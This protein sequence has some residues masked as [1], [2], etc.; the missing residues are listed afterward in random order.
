VEQSI[1]DNPQ[2]SGNAD[3]DDDGSDAAEAQRRHDAA[4]ESAE[5]VEYR[6]HSDPEDHRVFAE[7]NGEIAQRHDAVRNETAVTRGALIMPAPRVP[8]IDAD[9]ADNIHEAIEKRI[10]DRQNVP[11]ITGPMRKRLERIV[12]TLIRGKQVNARDR[13]QRVK[14]PG[15]FTTENILKWMDANNLT[16]VKSS[17]WS[18]A[19]FCSAI[20][21]LLKTVDPCYDFS[22]KVKAEPMAEK[23]PPRMLIA[24]GDKGQVMSLLVVK[25]I[26]DLTFSVYEGRSIK[27][28]AKDVAMTRVAYNLRHAPNKRGYQGKRVSALEGD[29]SAW[30]TTCTVPVRNMVENPIIMHVTQVFCDHCSLVPTSWHKEHYAACVEAGTTL[31]LAGGQT[32]AIWA[33]RRSGHRGTSILNWITNFVCWLATTLENGEVL[34]HPGALEATDLQGNKVCM[35]MAFEGDDSAIT[36]RGHNPGYIATIEENWKSLGFNMKLFERDHDKGEKM[37]FC[38]WF[39]SLNANGPTGEMCPDL[40]RSIRNMGISCSPAAVVAARDKDDNTLKAIATAKALSYAH[41]YRKYVP[42]LSKK[43]L[44]YARTLDGGITHLEQQDSFKVF[45]MAEP[46]EGTTFESLCLDIER[47][48]ITSEYENRILRTFGWGASEDEK[49]KFAQW[50]WDFDR[51]KG[52]S[53]YAVSIPPRWC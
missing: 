4:Q 42:T 7:E 31:K 12:N 8:R 26:E 23:K 43:L 45:G 46:P 3:D 38:G 16:D 52:F 6:V 15:V 1:Q 2:E 28:A 50:P 53:D 30:D 41:M 27:H 35:K 47:D 9:T 24:D 29:G 32:T 49:A 19:R 10:E 51:L 48:M 37:E 39:M 21:D 33:I 13:R 5:R 17:K 40:P 14:I 34:V 11:V 20:V 18:D 36:I 25:C 44:E 22:A